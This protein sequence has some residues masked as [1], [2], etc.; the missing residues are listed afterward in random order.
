MIRSLWLLTLAVVLGG[1][2]STSNAQDTWSSD[3]VCPNGTLE[4][5]YFGE[6]DD[7]VPGAEINGVEITDTTETQQNKLSGGQWTASS[8]LVAL[9]VESDDVTEFDFFEPSTS[10]SFTNDVLPQPRAI[11]GLRF[12]GAANSCPFSDFTENVNDRQNRVEIAIKDAEGVSAL[13]FTDGNGEPLLKNLKVELVEATGS[14]GTPVTFER[15]EAGNDIK[16]KATGSAL[17]TRI[18]M[19][20]NQKDLED[21]VVGY[22]LRSTNGCGTLTYIDPKRT[23]DRLPVEGVQVDGSFPNPFQQH[24]TIRFSL[25]ERLPVTISVYDV[26]G[27]QVVTLVDRTLSAGM[28][29]VQWNGRTDQAQAVSSGLYLYRIEAGPYREVRRMTLIQ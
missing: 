2:A 15:D 12:C 4:I 25:S 9:V 1:F 22:F 6:S 21:P 27:R 8:R 11:S 26:M 29:E 17:P 19:H 23:V 3:S 28:H 13:Q 20:L 5:A 7:I 24:T 18:I 10:G 16:W 14:N